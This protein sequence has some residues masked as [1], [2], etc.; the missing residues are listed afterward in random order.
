MGHQWDCG[1]LLED[2]DFK[3]KEAVAGGQIGL[4]GRVLP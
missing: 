2:V 3:G 1:W 4:G